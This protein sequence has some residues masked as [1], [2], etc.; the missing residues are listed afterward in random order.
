M[1]YSPIMW[2]VSPI[3]LSSTE[4][5]NNLL[6]LSILTGFKFQ[7]YSYMLWLNKFD[8]KF[9]EG[10]P[11]LHHQSPLIEI[12]IIFS[13]EHWRQHCVFMN[14]IQIWRPICRTLHIELR[15]R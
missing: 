1:Y 9:P 13:F 3:M 2:W 14:K 7:T 6:Q 5:K 4:N 15:C 11:S 10:A 12:S 8:E